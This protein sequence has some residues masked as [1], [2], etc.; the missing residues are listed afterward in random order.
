[1]RDNPNTWLRAALL[2][3]ACDPYSYPGDQQKLWT[4]YNTTQAGFAANFE[5]THN[6]LNGASAIDGT[7]VKEWAGDADVTVPL[8]ANGAL[9]SAACG[10]ELRVVSGLG[11]ATYT[12]DDIARWLIGSP[13]APVGTEILQLGFSTNT[14]LTTPGSVQIL[15]P[16]TIITDPATL[17]NPTTGIATIK[18]AG[19]YSLAAT[20]LF[21]GISSGAIFWIGWYVNGHP[22]FVDT[23][24]SAGSDISSR[25]CAE[26]YLDV[27]DRI[28]IA[29]Y[30]QTS[31]VAIDATFFAT[32]V[33]LAKVG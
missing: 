26:C 31:G 7:R 2:Y 18:T 11:H 14:P 33:T 19:I 27:G 22:T 1:M 30:V 13:M 10:S 5:P 20:A 9:L 24:A 32:F 15:I 16:D 21:D 29:A 6:A 3:A 8:S 4:A 25:S 23:S 28:Q 12:N 17:Y